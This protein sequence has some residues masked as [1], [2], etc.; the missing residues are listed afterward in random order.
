[1]LPALQVPSELTMWPQI[2]LCVWGGKRSGATGATGG[3]ASDRPATV[4]TRGQLH[5]F[6]LITIR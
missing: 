4:K 3:V 1:M 5:P 6:R 2:T